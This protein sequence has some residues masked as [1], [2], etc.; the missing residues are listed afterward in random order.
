MTQSQTGDSNKTSGKISRSRPK[1]VKHK[2][3][4]HQQRSR[5]NSKGHS[6]SSSKKQVNK[7]YHREEKLPANQSRSPSRT[8]SIGRRKSTTS[9]QTKSRRSVSHSPS[10]SKMEKN[11]QQ[12]DHN[13]QVEHTKSLQRGRPQGGQQRQALKE[14]NEYQLSEKN[15]DKQHQSKSSKKKLSGIQKEV[16]LMISIVFVGFFLSLID[17][18]GHTSSTNKIR[19]STNKKKIK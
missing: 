17:D 19:N 9:N 14:V 6:R 15:K 1:A 16:D 4:D 10:K 5:S 18:S 3:T 7:V 11:S 8:K 12:Q 13:I 2:Q